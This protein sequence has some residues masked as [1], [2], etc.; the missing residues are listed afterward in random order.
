MRARE[1]EEWKRK[2]GEKG[3]L[4]RRGGERGKVEVKGNCKR[5][6]R[7]GKKTG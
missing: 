1:E 5:M 7:K 3:E 4:G 6:Q 2:G